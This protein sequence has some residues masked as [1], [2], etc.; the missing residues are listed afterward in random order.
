MG[1]DGLWFYRP[2][3]AVVRP[4]WRTV[5]TGQVDKRE[6]S[7]GPLP[8]HHGRR[9][10]RSKPLRRVLHYRLQESQADD[11]CFHSTRMRARYDQ[12]HLLCSIRDESAAE[13]GPKFLYDPGRLVRTD[14]N[15]VGFQHRRHD[16]LRGVHVQ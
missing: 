4:G 13:H 11:E 5:R 6:H 9:R 14:R 2:G 8:L 15:R 12:V 3:P 1:H 16:L 10:F 7:R